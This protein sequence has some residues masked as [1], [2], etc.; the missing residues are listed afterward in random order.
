MLPPELIDLRGNG[1][2]GN[3]QRF[4]AKEVAAVP[5]FCGLSESAKVGLVTTAPKE[6]GRENDRGKD[7]EGDRKQRDGYPTGL[8][9][10]WGKYGAADSH[11]G[12]IAGLP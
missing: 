5:A 4:E 11:L 12:I 10:G 6:G 2:V 8:L 7:D 1:G 9:P 3:S